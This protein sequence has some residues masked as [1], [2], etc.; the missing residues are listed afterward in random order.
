MLRIIAWNINGVQDSKISLW[1]AA[2]YLRDFDVI[3][4]SET[5]AV[6]ISDHLF[7]DYSLAYCPAS[8]E[9]RGGEGILVAVR[10][11]RLYH[12]QDFGSDDSSLWVRLCFNNSRRPLILGAV[13]IPPAGSS[14]LQTVD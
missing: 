12:V 8:E 10:K 2:Q 1:D 3:L 9:G 7:T 5:R 13:Y 6:Q 14:H 4:L 11:H